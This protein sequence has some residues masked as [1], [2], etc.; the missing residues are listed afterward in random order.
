MSMSLSCQCH[1]HLL[2]VGPFSPGTTRASS[3]CF[4]DSFSRGPISLKFARSISDFLRDAAEDDRCVEGV[5][6]RPILAE[7]LARTLSSDGDGG[8]EVLPSKIIP[9]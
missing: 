3:T 7:A 4:N 9:S 6:G 8:E 5:L 2:I 1:Y